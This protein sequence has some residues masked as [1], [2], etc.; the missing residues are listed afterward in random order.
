M[1]SP[2]DQYNER[3]IEQSSMPHLF[4]RPAIPTYTITHYGVVCRIPVVDT[5]HFSVALL[6]C[7][8]SDGYVGLVLTPCPDSEDIREP[9]YHPGVTFSGSSGQLRTVRIVNLG[10]DLGALRFDDAPI[11]FAWKEISLALRP[12]L[13]SKRLPRLTSHPTP[14]SVDAETLNVLTLF[15]FE[16]YPTQIPRSWTQ[17]LSIDVIFQCPGPGGSRILLAI[18]RCPQHTPSSTGNSCVSQE[19]WANIWIIPSQGSQSEHPPPHNCHEHH[20][21]EWPNLRKL[22]DESYDGYSIP[23]VISFHPHPRDPKSAMVLGTV[24][25]GR[26]Y[27]FGKSWFLRYPLPEYAQDS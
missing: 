11:T 7:S 23:V 4:P 12:A 19:H 21:C 17:S 1:F 26:R 25:F 15:G 27:G 13:S 18:G 20:I 22:F 9:L 5:P 6:F 3:R 14:S 10:H 8:D 16:P 2:Q 24:R